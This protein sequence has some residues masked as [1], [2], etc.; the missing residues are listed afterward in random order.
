ML[1]GGNHRQVE[2]QTPILRHLLSDVS[3]W[4]GGEAKRPIVGWLWLVMSTAGWYSHG[5]VLPWTTGTLHGTPVSGC[6][7]LGNAVHAK[8]LQWG[9]LPYSQSQSMGRIG[10]N[11]KLL[12][13]SIST[14]QGRFSK[15][16]VVT[17]YAV[18]IA[19]YLF[20]WQY[21]LRLQVR[22][23]SS[24]FLMTLIHL[25]GRNNLQ[26]SSKMSDILK[27]ICKHHL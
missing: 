22:D 27:K 18:S 1:I 9:S 4:L 23:G 3:D 12:N 20:L 16:N 21:Q 26:T 8:T 10:F 25:V 15:H 13:V 24:P 14:S 7:P 2:T 17:Q 19:K 5:V 6:S 11:E